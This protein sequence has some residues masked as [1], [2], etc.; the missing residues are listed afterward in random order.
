MPSV[1]KAQRSISC[2]ALS[3]L[4]GKMSHDKSPQAHKMMQTMSKEELT[5]MCHTSDEEMMVAKK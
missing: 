5:K 1:S 3:M 4:E 2:M